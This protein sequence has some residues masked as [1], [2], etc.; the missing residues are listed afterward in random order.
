MKLI[1]ATLGATITTPTR[2]PIADRGIAWSTT[3][4]ITEVDPANSEGGTAGGSFSLSFDGVSFDAGSNLLSTLPRGT[5]IYYKGYVTNESGTIYSTEQSFNNTPIFTGTGNW[6]TAVRWNVN[7][8]IPG[9]NGSANGSILDSPIIDGNCTL[10]VSNSVTDLTINSGRKITINTGIINSGNELNVIGTL[11]NNS[12][13]SGI[14][15]KSD[16]NVANGSLIWASGNPTGT[17]EMWSK[18]YTDTK[19]HW[20]YFGI[21]VT[22][23]NANVPFSGSGVRVRRYNEANHDASNNDFGLWLP[24]ASGATM[25]TTNDPMYPVVGYEVTQPKEAKFTFSGTLNHND[26]INYSLGYTSG[27]DWQGDNIIANPFVSAIDIS[28]ITLTNT[29]GSVYLYNAGS[30]DEWT[31]N[32]GTSTDGESPGQYTGSNG[33]FAGNLGTPKEIPSMQGF[34]VKATS[35][36]AK[37]SIPYSSAI[38]NAKL[39]RV[40]QIKQTAIAGTRIDVT[41]TNFSDKMWIFIADNCSKN[42]DC[43]Y[44]AVKLLGSVSTPQIFAT[45]LGGDLQID[46][47]NEMNN[48]LLSFMPGSETSLKLKFTHQNLESK[49]SSIYLVDLLDNK[50]IDVTASG[51]EYL[52]TA[53]ST[54]TPTSRFKIITTPLTTTGINSQNNDSS[55][56]IFSSQAT[57]YVENQSDKSGNIIVY[58][59]AGCAIRHAILEPN[60]ITN[61][62]NLESC[63]YIVKATTDSE[64]TTQRLIIR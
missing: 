59:M 3:P 58:N 20:Q 32:S 61:L 11:T 15:V 60:G 41:G 33:A 36:N 18:A 42:F 64:N 17:V 4:G 39:Q 54:P 6:E 56:K 55:I 52:F 12:N 30:R 27:A 14:L 35:T 13:E 26:V 25:A 46:A 21:P 50:T 22:G 34:L 63:A 49:Y 47:V 43:G 9:S 19:Y 10:N 23:I 1:S 57:I 29:D 48:T 8:D 31:A 62:N 40:P 28:K 53:T 37:I 5:T 2:S 51:T 45:E 7:G 44:D 24:S 16:K 38:V